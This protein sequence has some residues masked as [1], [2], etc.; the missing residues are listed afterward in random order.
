M[1]HELRP[2]LPL[3]WF[4]TVQILGL[5]SAWFARVHQG[6]HRQSAYNSVFYL[7][8]AVVGATTIVAAITSPTGSI[9]TGTALAVMVLT[10]VWDFHSGR[11]TLGY[12]GNMTR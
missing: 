5:M 1:P 6:S 7:L 4:A 12:H 2:F 11:K 8:L 9:V 10:T 3:W